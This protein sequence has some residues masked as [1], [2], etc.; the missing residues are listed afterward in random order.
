MSSMMH[1][2]M[3]KE[4]MMVSRRLRR[5][6]FCMRLLIT[7]K[8]SEGMGQGKQV[9]SLQSDI[10]TIFNQ[11]LPSLNKTHTTRAISSPLG[12]YSTYDIKGCRQLE[13]LKTQ[14]CE[15]G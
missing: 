10:Y 12:K 8:R 9:G 14:F 5:F 3:T 13:P 2:A 15:E 7:G 11:S 4:R 1:T 6:T